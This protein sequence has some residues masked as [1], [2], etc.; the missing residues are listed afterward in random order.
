MR[1]D[2]TKALV[3][4][5]NSG[6]RGGATTARTESNAGIHGGGG[7]EDSGKAGAL[8]GGEKKRVE[9]KLD[10]DSTP[11]QSAAPP[12]LTREMSTPHTTSKSTPVAKLKLTLLG[13]KD[14]CMS[15]ERSWIGTH[16]K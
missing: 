11:N 6:G 7:G 8:G 2:R 1:H 9:E 14:W 5:G 15:R 13:E 16:T 4:P 3:V 10:G 12:R